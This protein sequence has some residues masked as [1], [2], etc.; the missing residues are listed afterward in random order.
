M[1][2]YTAVP[3]DGWGSVCLCKSVLFGIL[4]FVWYLDILVSILFS[5]FVNFLGFVLCIIRD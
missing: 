4:M 5:I 2:L 1:A 3:L